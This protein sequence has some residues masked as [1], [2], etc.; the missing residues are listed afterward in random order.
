MF[1]ARSV[2]PRICL[3]KVLDCCKA[4]RCPIKLNK[5]DMLIAFK[6]GNACICANR[7]SWDVAVGIESFLFNTLVSVFSYGVP[8][9]TVFFSSRS[10]KD[11]DLLLTQGADKR[12]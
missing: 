6:N 5:L 9:D 11:K 3:S 7:L 4:Q 1:I 2:I 10:S 8:D 12:S